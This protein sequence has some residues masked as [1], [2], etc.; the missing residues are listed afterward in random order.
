VKKTFLD[1]GLQP[2]TNA[3]SSI[4]NPKGEF[5]YPLQVQ[6]DDE[7]K[8][9][10]LKNFVKPGLMFNDTYAHRASMSA[11]MRESF[12]LVASQMK[13]AYRPKK[14]L[15]IGSNDGAFIRN[16]EKEE[17]IAVE[18]CKNLAEITQELGFITYPE[19]WDIAQAEKIVAIHGKIDLI[20]SANTISHIPELK[21]AFNAVASTL[22]Q[23]GIFVFEDPS[24]LSVIVNGSYDQFYDEHPHVFSVMALENILNYCGL[25]IF[26]VENLNTHGG[27]NRI[28]AQRINGGEMPISIN[29]ALNIDREEKAGLA[30][31]GKYKEFGERVK[32]S[33]NDLV[34]LLKDLKVQQK[35]IVSYGAT[36]KSATIFN[37]CNIGGSLID[38]I[39]DTTPNKQGK[40]SPGMHIPIISPEEGF[41]ASVDYAFL[42]AW[43]FSAEILKNEVRYVSRGGKFITHVPQVRVI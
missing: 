12:R 2:I 36:Y 21:E 41:N 14:T 42:G 15:E 3:F 25:E 43:N 29:V 32:K 23:K 7:S 33:K 22:S 26:D 27:S 8:L 20:Y 30:T 16:F 24:L 38:Y 34:K 1:L 18:P 11:T 13:E 9:V 5:F 40:F 17:V 19:F 39:V 37:Y 6:F 35:K 10:S 28:Y 4:S 31:I